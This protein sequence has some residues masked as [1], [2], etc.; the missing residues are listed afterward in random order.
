MADDDRTIRVKVPASVLYEFDKIS[1][2][3]EKTLG[4]LG[5]PACCSG[6]DIRFE[7]ERKFVADN[8]LDVKMDK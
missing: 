5:C 6:H 8:N 3:L 4:E 2:V 7:I 1:K